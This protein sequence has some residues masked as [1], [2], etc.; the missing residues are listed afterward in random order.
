M[1]RAGFFRANVTEA[2]VPCVPGSAEAET[3]APSVWIAA[4]VP[5]R[6]ADTEAREDG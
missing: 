2:T 6:L 3:E 4:M 5:M 1:K